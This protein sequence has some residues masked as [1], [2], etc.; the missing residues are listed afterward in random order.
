MDPT[1]ALQ[2]S[3][4]E[5]YLQPKKSSDDV[6][7]TDTTNGDDTQSVQDAEDDDD[8]APLWTE[9]NWTG[10]DEEAA[11]SAIVE[12]VA[13]CQLSEPLRRRLPTDSQAW[14]RFYRQHQTNFFKDRHY[15]ATAFPHE[16]AVSRQSSTKQEKRTLVEIGCGV[17]NTLLPL[18]ER[19]ETEWTVYGMD[20]SAVAIDLL[21][22]D[23][24]FVRAAAASRAWAGVADLVHD[25]MPV[26]CRQV[27]DVATLLF[28]LSAIHPDHHSQAAAAAVQALQPGGT[29]V[30]R[31]YGRYDQAELQLARQRAKRL[32]DHYYVK[33]DQTK[34]YY[35][36]KED[37]RRLFV[38]EQ[39]LEELEN[40]YI[41]RQYQNRGDGTRRRRVW[42][43]ARFR[44][45]P[46]EASHVER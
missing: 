36:T 41:Q 9:D 30:V 13:K 18:L 7:T 10:Q 4:Y 25:G 1:F 2:Y 43:Q 11:R 27:A 39:G 17:G 26:A 32:T 34:C 44:R 6:A 28:C 3:Y 20:L 46:A 14:D 8:A 42:V 40:E 5:L 19:E 29:L 35:F 16:F 24:R 21:Q 31:D 38:E 45:R 23:E 15:L 22:Q 37:L 33:H 12:N